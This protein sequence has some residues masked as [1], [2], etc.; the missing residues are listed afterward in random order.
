MNHK[1]LRIFKL[2]MNKWSVDYSFKIIIL[3]DSG[4]GKTNII[5]RYTMNEFNFTNSTIG[6]DYYRKIIIHDNKKFNIQYWDT[7]GKERYKTVTASHYRI[8]NGIMLVY[9][10]TN[11]SSFEYVQKWIDQIYLNIGIDIPILLIGNK[12]DL[13]FKRVITTEEG[14]LFANQYHILFI[15]M[16]AIVNVGIEFGI[17]KLIEEI[18]EKNKNKVNDEKK[19]IDN[20]HLNSIENKKQI[21]YK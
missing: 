18:Y 9:D 20:I 7:A 19:K 16:S 8:S 3:G 6:V 14:L 5:C 2:K 13:D 17:S 15:E 12:S 1:D 10:I 21:C 4:V 11:R